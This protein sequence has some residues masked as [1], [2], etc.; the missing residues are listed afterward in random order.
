VS[1]DPRRDPADDRVHFGT[2]RAGTALGGLHWRQLALLV[3]AGLWALVWTRTTTGAL[4]PVIGIAG[5]GLVAGAGLSRAGGRLPID[6]GWVGGGFAVRMARGQTRYRRRPGDRTPRL[7]AHLG[8]VRLL[9][10]ATDQGDIGLIRD[11]AM[12]VAVL[13]VT[14]EPFV[15]ADTDE[16]AA[17]R[18]AW[19]A[20]LA[21]LARPGSSVVRVQWI[22]RS[23]RLGPR[24]RSRYVAPEV[25]AHAEEPSV[26]SYLAL[27]DAVARDAQ[28]YELLIAI[29]I[30]AQRVHDRRTGV[31][32]DPRPQQALDAAVQVAEQLAA[33]G[34]GS[35]RIMRPD[36]LT[37]AIRVGGDPTA[38]DLISDSPHGPDA[39]PL[40]PTDPGPMAAHESWGAYR[41]DGAWHATF[42]I[43][44][45]PRGEAD[46][47]VLAP[48][49]L[50]GR[51]GRVTS[52]V[53]QPCDPAR[54]VR[55][56]E[57]AR[58]QYAA[59]DELR[60]RA[61]F[62]GSV[63]R[64]RQQAAI[65]AHER[66]LADGHA[67]YRFCGYV[68]VSDPTRD[69]LESACLA[70]ATSAQLARCEVRRLWGEQAAG[71]GCTLPLCRGLA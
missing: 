36:E 15:L 48:L 33:S 58:L 37:R 65:S 61:G 10:I 17:H 42:W 3:I 56:A 53:M 24:A 47:D 68:T 4:G 35:A 25:G 60:E 20:M 52:V 32:R 62:M 69:G 59:D 8:G 39:P 45:W 21:G 34:L 22:T 63:R 30:G 41:C 31:R 14:A 51:P 12:L 54:A 26:R 23:A 7:P 11:R 43:S 2:P 18:A 49:L 64:R 71:L 13:S 50:A 27:V 6:W 28:E 38:G 57:Q 66:E 5:A 46:A 1:D 70:L 19:G 16:M 9:G 44:Q 29:G 40:D 55:D 67:A